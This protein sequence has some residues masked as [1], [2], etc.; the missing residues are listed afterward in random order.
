MLKKEFVEQHEDGVVFYRLYSDVGM[1]V[2]QVET[3]NIY[4]EVCITDDDPHTYE[5][6]CEAEDEISDEEALRIITEGMV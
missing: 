3:G 4:G 1:S 6:Y 2:L 5:E